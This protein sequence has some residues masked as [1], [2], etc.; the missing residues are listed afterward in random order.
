MSA[1]QPTLFADDPIDVAALDALAARSLSRAELQAAGYC[2]VAKSTDLFPHGYSVLH[3]IKP[4]QA[5]E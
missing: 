3:W 4:E 1:K 5:G 2:P